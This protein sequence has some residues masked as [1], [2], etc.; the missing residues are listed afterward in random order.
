MLDTEIPKEQ[1]LLWLQEY[2][3]D[4]FI[5]ERLL[6]ELDIFGKDKYVPSLQDAEYNKGFARVYDIRCKIADSPKNREVKERHN[7]HF[8]KNMK[9]ASKAKGAFYVVGEELG[10]LAFSLYLSENK[11]MLFLSILEMDGVGY[12]K[13]SMKIK[14]KL[15]L[16]EIIPSRYWKK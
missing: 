1:V 4:H 11:E 7:G 14:R 16:S 8:Y 2:D 12:S 6:F 13:K 5:K 3:Y 15:K 9:K 10:S